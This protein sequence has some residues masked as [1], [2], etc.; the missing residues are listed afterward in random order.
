MSSARAR[1]A[2]EQADAAGYADA[3]AAYAGLGRDE[4]QP[5]ALR[6]LA[7]RP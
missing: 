1:T 7:E 6:A 3:V 2:A 5:A 4:L